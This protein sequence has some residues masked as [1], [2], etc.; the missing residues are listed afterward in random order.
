MCHKQ[1]EAHCKRSCKGDNTL[2]LAHTKTQPQ[3][4]RGSL[5]CGQAKVLCVSTVQG[6]QL[7][8]TLIRKCGTATLVGSTPS[9]KHPGGQ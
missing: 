7:L 5:L 9:Q 6:L 3:L 8:D 2:P 4:S 1:T